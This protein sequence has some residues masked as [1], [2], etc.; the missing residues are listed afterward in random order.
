MPTPGIKLVW[1]GWR[2]DPLIGF[3]NRGYSRWHE[4]LERG[5]RMLVYETTGKAP[6]SKA[7]GTRSIVGEVE[8]AGTFEEGEAHRAPTEQHDRLLPVETRIS[9][10]NAHPIPLERVRELIDDPGWPRMGETW[11]PLTDAQYQAL[12]DALTN[13]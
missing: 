3:S 7:K 10:T 2:D 4:S 1:A 6:G 11:K 12:I 8:V 9:R 5:T 13:G